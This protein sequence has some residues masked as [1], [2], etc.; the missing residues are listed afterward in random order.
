[1]SEP[2]VFI[3]HFLI[4]EGGLDA[5]R[6]LQQ[7]VAAAGVTLNVQAEHVAGFMRP[8]RDGRS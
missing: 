4:K 7:E 8:V 1:M 3:S 6:Q 5:Y 2:I